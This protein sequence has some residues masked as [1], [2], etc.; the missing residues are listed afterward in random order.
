MS[1]RFPLYI[2]GIELFTSF[3]SCTDMVTP[4]EVRQIDSLKGK[5]NTYR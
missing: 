3:F 4:K 5:A 2:I 1:S